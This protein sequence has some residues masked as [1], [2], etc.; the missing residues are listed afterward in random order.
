VQ[1]TAV[2]IG[3]RGRSVTTLRPAGKARF[4]ERLVDVVAEGDFLAADIAIEVME[5][6][7]N[8]VVVRPIREE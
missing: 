6:R 8:R 1:E 5:V 4:G 2:H 7:G 3:E